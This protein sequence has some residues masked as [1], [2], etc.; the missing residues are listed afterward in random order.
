MDFYPELKYVQIFQSINRDINP[1]ALAR[2]VIYLFMDWKN[3]TYNNNEVN[4]NE[5]NISRFLA[6]LI[7][8]IR[9][10]IAV[11]S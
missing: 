3:C 9:C 2:G 6:H 5:V 11:E 4:N 8:H 7:F 10:A 1:R